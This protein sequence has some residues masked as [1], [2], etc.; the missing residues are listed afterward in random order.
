M[1]IFHQ[2]LKWFVAEVEDVD[3]RIR[4]LINQPLSPPD[5]CRYDYSVYG[6][7]LASNTET[8]QIEVTQAI[9]MLKA[10]L[11]RYMRPIDNVLDASGLLAVLKSN[12]LLRELKGNRHFVVLG[13]EIVGIALSPPL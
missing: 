13:G 3:L 5:A 9:Y 6:Y 8:G 1:P 11:Q 2:G 7:A 4:Q 10:T 12:Q